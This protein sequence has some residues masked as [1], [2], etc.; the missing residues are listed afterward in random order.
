M[1]RLD[2]IVRGSKGDE[3]NISFTRDYDNLTA[4]CTCRAGEV[5]MYCKHRFALM[6]GDVTN[7]ISNNYND[8]AKI[9][10]LIA[11]SDVEAAIVSLK[12]AELALDDAKKE[13]SRRKKA[14]ARAMAD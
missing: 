13:V 2:F 3:Y 12:N 14:L 7:L 9:K 6:E 10:E 8:V 4:R 1:R 11:G 5:G